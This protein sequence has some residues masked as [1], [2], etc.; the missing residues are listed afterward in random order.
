MPSRWAFPDRPL[1]PFW[2]GEIE[3][4]I[5]GFETRARIRKEGIEVVS[6]WPGEFQFAD[7]SCCRSDVNKIADRID[8]QKTANA[9]HANAR[10]H[11]YTGNA[12][13]RGWGDEELVK[14]TVARRYLIHLE[15]YRPPPS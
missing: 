7:K 3:R 1:V 5:N 10:R 4:D 14:M 9:E 8:P 13:K 6:G 11:S 15:V 2:N 12:G